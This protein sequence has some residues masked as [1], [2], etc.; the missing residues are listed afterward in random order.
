MASESEGIL[1]GVEGTGD[2][3]TV[4]LGGGKLL[5]LLVLGL[6][7]LCLAAGERLLSSRGCSSSS[8]ERERATL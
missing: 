2:A 8:R 6:G 1:V 5:V 7:L 3:D 4:V